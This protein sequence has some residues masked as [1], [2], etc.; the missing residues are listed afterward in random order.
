[1]RIEPTD[2]RQA[3]GNSDSVKAEIGLKTV[4]LLVSEEVFYYK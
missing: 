4:R 2:C 1:M 3:G